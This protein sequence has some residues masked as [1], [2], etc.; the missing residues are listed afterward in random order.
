MTGP[1]AGRGVTVTYEWVSDSE[2]VIHAELQPGQAATLA[3]SLAKKK[4]KLNARQ[5]ML[6]ELVEYFSDVTWL[7]QPKIKSE[8]SKA[9]LSI[10]WWQ[11]L[12]ELYTL[13]GGDM[14]KTKT[15]IRRTVERMRQDNLTISA[16]QS[17]LNVALDE[18]AKTRGGQGVQVW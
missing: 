10:R 6:K 4:R 12:E 5:E 17:I 11:P 14:A 7:P 2:L 8:R 9:G 16:P 15:L 18:Y 3:T 1:N 13:T